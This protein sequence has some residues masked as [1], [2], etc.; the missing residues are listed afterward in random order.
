VAASFG[1]KDEELHTKDLDALSCIVR[2]FGKYIVVA[3]SLVQN[4]ASGQLQLLVASNKSNPTSDMQAVFTIFKDRN[5][6]KDKQKAFN[7]CLPGAQGKIN[8]MTFIKIGKFFGNLSV[9]NIID[10]NKKVKAYDG[11]HA[12]MKIVD[13]IMRGKFSDAYHKNTILIGT[14]PNACLKCHRTYQSLINLPV[15][16]N[17]NGS[18]G[19]PFSTWVPPQFLQGNTWIDWNKFAD[20]C[21]GKYFEKTKGQDPLSLLKDL[22]LASGK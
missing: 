1:S 13:Y 16:F 2:K 12:E 19:I 11:V 21:V 3:V 6:P 9:G 15:K 7:A 10:V 17:Y 18:S 22:K 20:P 14:H 5:I 8:A 4:E